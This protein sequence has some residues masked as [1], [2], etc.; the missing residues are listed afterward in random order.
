MALATL[1]DFVE[2]MKASK[3]TLSWLIWL[4]GKEPFFE[5]HYLLLT[6]MELTTFILSVDMTRSLRQDNKPLFPLPEQTLRDAQ[7]DQSAD[8]FVF[9]AQTLHSA[10]WQQIFPPNHYMI[11]TFDELQR[12]VEVT[13]LKTARNQQWRVVNFVIFRMYPIVH[14]LLSLGL[15]VSPNDKWS[16]VQEA[17][18]LGI[19]LFLG[20]I[21]RQCGALGVST[22]LYV[23]KLKFLMENL[24]TTVDWTSANLLL[25][26]IMFFGLLESWELPEQ[27]WYVE[28]IHAVMVRTTLRSWDAVVERVKSF[29]WVDE[30]YD[31]RIELFRDI[32]SSE[33]RSSF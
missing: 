28:S 20:E 2:V 23:T 3:I 7:N 25:L 18:R 27:D 5:I 22:K 1:F 26:W 14:R 9:F 17:S 16:I 33:E 11:S 13:R 6:N 31:E 19:L 15:V 10:P 21:R 24:G 4:M 32:V 12:A 30:I 8:D 29:L